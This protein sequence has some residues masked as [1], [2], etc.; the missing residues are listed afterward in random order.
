MCEIEETEGESRTTET[1]GCTDIAGAAAVAV[2]VCNLL[3]AAG[4]LLLLLCD[5][6]ADTHWVLV[7][8]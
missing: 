5:V 8:A 1:G 4:L 6:V 3:G 7:L 2:G